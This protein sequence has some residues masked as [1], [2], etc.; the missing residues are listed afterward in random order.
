MVG[1]FC[2]ARYP[3]TRSRSSA[4]LLFVRAWG[5]VPLDGG[6][7]C[8]SAAACCVMTVRG[9]G[10]SVAVSQRVVFQDR[11]FAWTF[12]HFLF[13]ISAQDQFKK[14]IR[15]AELQQDIFSSTQ[16]WP[17][18]SQGNLSSFPAPCVTLSKSPGRGADLNKMLDSQGCPGVQQPWQQGKLLCSSP[19]R[20]A[21][22]E[23]C[24]CICGMVGPKLRITDTT[25]RHQGHVKLWKRNYPLIAQLGGVKLSAF[26]VVVPCDDA[27]SIQVAFYCRK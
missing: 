10:H 18:V 14:K 13:F 17:W 5:F 4:Q 21:E 2:R 1:I 7:G 19:R 9:K 11:G 27:Q 20:G 25:H 26:N 23:E 24:S 6:W 3:L 16:V 15:N 12:F 8:P 22:R